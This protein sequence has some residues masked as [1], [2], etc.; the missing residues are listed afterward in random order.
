MNIFAGGA[1]GNPELKANPAFIHD[2]T[3]RY[4]SLTPHE[5]RN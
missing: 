1:Q 5:R 4:E 2:E 3:A